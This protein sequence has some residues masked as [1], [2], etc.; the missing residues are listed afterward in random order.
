MRQYEQIQTR[1]I[2]SAYGGVG[3]IIETR[4][5]AILIEDFN[6]WPYF[7]NE[8]DFEECN[9]AEDKRFLNRL[10]MYF[11]DLEKLIKVHINEFQKGK[12]KDKLALISAKY[13]PEWF[14]CH[15]CHR[16]D[17]LENW[18]KY[19]NNN[20]DKD[21]KENFY[22]PKCY[23][24]YVKNRKGKKKFFELEQVRFILI[25]SNGEVADIPW[26]K[27]AWYKIQN[28]LKGKEKI[29]EE[30]EITL[31]NIN[32]E[33]K[34]LSF[35]YRTSDKLDDLK[36]IL[37]KV[38]E[39]GKEIGYA[40]LSGLF[41]LQVKLQD[42]FPDRKNTEAEFKVVIRSSNSVYY[43]N[44]LHSIFIPSSFIL[45]KKNI[46]LIKASFDKG[47][48]VKQIVEGLENFQ[49]IKIGEKV[50]QK[51]IDSNFSLEEFEQS[52]SEN[53]YRYDEYKFI[54]EKDNEDIEGKLIFS[55][56]NRNYYQNTLIK[57]VYK[58]SKI[59]MTSV[60]TSYTRQE[61]I[62]IESYLEDN[63]EETKKKVPIIKK[64]TSWKG[65][66]TKYLPAVE[67]YGEGVFF[68]FNDD[69]LNE[70]ISNNPKIEERIE[71]IERNHRNLETNL[72]K[73]LIITPKYV[74]IHT[75]SH[76]IIKE[77]E[78]LCGYPSTSIQERIYIDNEL[79]MNGV[80]IYTVAGTEGSY[81]GITSI[82]DSEQIGKLIV[83]AM[84]RATDC[85]TDPICYHSDG[86][87][88]GKLNLSACFSCTLLP[89][90]SCEMFN[91][92]LDRRILID[93]EY[94]YFKD[95]LPSFIG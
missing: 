19:W 52:K 33:G 73:D 10:K 80:L 61:P 11:K 71:E 24:C 35:E 65:K 32:L 78:Y 22:P 58:M 29:D 2:I 48:N 95:L 70:W 76:L 25:S 88:V 86:Q 82:C 20:V 91:S 79:K 93:K 84:M 60:Q 62:S 37:I 39:N 46:E 89:E 68:E 49:G 57:S 75:F 56:V 55:K 81:G 45:S 53:E 94:G 41:N 38:K 90:T 51:L 74:L 12:P 30:E 1:K 17:K 16:F 50:I 64:F 5:G 44:I 34:E 8:E 77:L 15:N 85:A 66:N 13:F 83:S 28:K 9:Y 43:P 27:W 69:V 18:K 54:T 67:S 42:I 26:D 7:Q 14:Y 21:D 23:H 31:A 92:Y 47:M 4:D 63:E 72:N 87:G 40:T 59:K 6:R 36:G 3:S